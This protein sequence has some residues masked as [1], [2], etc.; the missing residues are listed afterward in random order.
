[1][2]LADD[3]SNWKT[4]ITRTSASRHPKLYKNPQS[5]RC[6][7]ISS[8][9]LFPKFFFFQHYNHTAN[10]IPRCLQSHLIISA[11]RHQR[12][13][14]S[15]PAY[16]LKTRSRHTEV[17]TPLQTISPAFFIADLCATLGEFRPKTLSHLLRY[18]N[19]GS[20]DLVANCMQCCI[21]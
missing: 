16:M 11:M 19:Y 15:P 17:L 8:K 9:L 13:S 4:L 7:I 20:L 21:K 14:C 12:T 18:R 3:C 5:T 2:I 6:I 1:M 10:Y